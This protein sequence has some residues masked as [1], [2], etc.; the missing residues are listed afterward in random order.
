MRWRS[1]KLTIGGSKYEIVNI[2][3]A[4]TTRAVGIS[5]NTL[6]SISRCP[7]RFDTCRAEIRRA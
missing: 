7:R 3:L 2:W 4:L 6:S 1:F 5:H